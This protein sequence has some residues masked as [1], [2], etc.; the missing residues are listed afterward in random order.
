MRRGILQEHHLP[1][2]SPEVQEMSCIDIGSRVG[3]AGAAL[4]ERVWNKA[5]P[6]QQRETWVMKCCHLRPPYPS[7]CKRFLMLMTNCTVV[8]SVEL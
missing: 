1:H 8:C 2:L 6:P 7:L 5:A 4:L 3:W